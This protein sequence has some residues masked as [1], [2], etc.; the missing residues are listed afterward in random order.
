MGAGEGGGG[1]A[2]SERGGDGG[3]REVGRGKEEKSKQL[4]QT[5]TIK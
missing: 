1:V 5:K 2:E 3:E 4:N